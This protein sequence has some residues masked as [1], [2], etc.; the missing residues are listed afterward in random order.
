LYFESIQAG[1]PVASN[2]GAQSFLGLGY[3]FRLQRQAHSSRPSHAN[4]GST[5]TRLSRHSVDRKPVSIVLV[6][7][8]ASLANPSADFDYFEL[9]Q[10]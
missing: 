5:W 3:V 9:Y 7:A 6:T 4:D 1:A 2:F 10:Q 8:Q